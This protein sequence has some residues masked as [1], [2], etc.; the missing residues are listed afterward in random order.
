MQRKKSAESV[1]GSV[2]Q[3]IRFVLPVYWRERKAL[4]L[5]CALAVPMR[6][7]LPFAGI[8]MPKLVIDQIQAG[9][10]TERFLLLV[11]GMALLL[12]VLNY[13]KSF[14]D[15]IVNESVGTVGIMKM[16]VRQSEKRMRMDYELM[17][18][19][20]A[21]AVADK[22][23]KALTSN[24][25][26][27]MNIPR[28]AVEV[29]SN[30]AGLLL[31]ATVIL[32]VHPAILLVLLLSAI[33]NWR[34]MDSLRRYIESTRE[35][36]SKLYRQFDVLQKAL[37][38]E[39]AAKDIRLYGAFGWLH[40]RVKKQLDLYGN[41]EDQVG[42]RKMRT[43]LL[44]G[45]LVFLRDGLAY[46]FLIYLLLNGRLSLGDFV[47]VFAAVG[48]IAGWIAGL[49][50][51]AG[52]LH[53]ASLEMADIRAFLNQPDRMNT[54]E[55]IPLPMGDAPAL[56]ITCA[57]VEY[58]YPKAEK[59]A[60]R[61]IRFTIRPGE[62]VA[63]VGTNGAG[64]TTLVKLL[65]GLYVPT[66][67]QVL[68]NGQPVAAYNRDEYYSLFSPVFQDIHLLSCDIAGNVSQ[69]TPE[70][71]D[72]DR[73][74][75]CLRLAGLWEK[76]QSLEKKERTMLVRSVH[77][78]AIELSGGE[79]QKLALARALYKNA[80]VLVLDEPTAALD[81]IAENEVYQKYAE[82]TRGK[83]SVFISHRLA[84]TRFCDRILLLDGSTVA[85]E[86]THE[87]LMR[88]NGIYARMFSVQASYYQSVPEGEKGEMA[89]G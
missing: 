24:H 4:V 15:A 72:M 78:D 32:T 20:G 44:D 76:V 67:G 83:T 12:T 47:F 29:L 79:K 35:E 3:M 19:P 41:A 89:N 37:K 45:L 80:P 1:S 55:G 69:R 75:H 84:S 87:E 2:V 31:Y 62:R 85:E 65:C 50:T 81:P 5:L 43:K 38:D 86:G 58:T 60:L 33:L 71:T 6:V 82:L 57:G 54:G 42:V 17:E 13:L 16:L 28:L 59:P 30:T 18:D 48:A 49:L 23:D 22:A 64:K 56:S 7:G 52:D 11:G 25:A 34:A 66:G 46:A 8:F 27:G 40:G 10:G 26:L 88:L 68:L 63:I 39:E 74:F 77:S 51:A 36:R 21:K 61:D 73:V 14:T 9:A 53:K 70:E